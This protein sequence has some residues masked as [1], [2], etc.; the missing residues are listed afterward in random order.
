MSN[1]VPSTFFGSMLRG[2]GA[3]EHQYHGDGASWGEW[4]G[5]FQGLDGEPF[6]IPAQRSMPGRPAP[7]PGQ[8]G[9]H[10]KADALAE[11]IKYRRVPI[12]PPFANLALDPRVIYMARLRALFFGGN[13]S[14]AQ[15][16][17]PDTY[18]FSLPTIVIGRSAGA[19][20]ADDVAL[21]FGRTQGTIW[22]GFFQR[23]GG[24]DNLDGGTTP[25]VG[26]AAFGTGSAPMLYPGNGIFFDKGSS[27][28]LTVASLIDNARIEVVIWCVEEYANLSR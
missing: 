28:S 2:A 7:N 11:G 9:P 24:N 18:Q 22:G 26:E 3:P 25:I 5:E 17:A 1:R 20:L 15:T 27:L 19:Y 13:G 4:G 6:G 21:P 8:G 16:F 14:A 10:S 23:V 12:Y